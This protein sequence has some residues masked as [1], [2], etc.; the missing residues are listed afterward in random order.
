L[1]FF[2]NR[3]VTSQQ[4]D[5]TGAHRLRGILLGNFWADGYEGDKVLAEAKALCE[6]FKEKARTRG[7]SLETWII[8][9]NVRNACET[10]Q[11][12]PYQITH[13]PL[14]QLPHPSVQS[15]A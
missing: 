2:D 10:G 14:E 4:L 6:R 9:H 7:L 3:I 13:L 1:W 5:V 15:P 11:H 12:K 8:W